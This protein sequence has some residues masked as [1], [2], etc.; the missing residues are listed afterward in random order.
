M[1][2]KITDGKVENLVAQIQ[3]P[4]AGTITEII[5]RPGQRVQQGDPLAIIKN[6]DRMILEALFPSTRLDKVSK[7]VD[8]SFRTGISGKAKLISQLG[9]R[10]ISEES[11]GMERAGFSRFLEFEN[12]N[13]Q[14]AEGT[15]VSIRVL[16]EANQQCLAIPVEAVQEEQ[17]LDLVYVQSGGET[18][19][20]RYPQLG[21]SDGQWIEVLIGVSGRT[22][23]TRGAQM[24]RLSLWVKWKWDMAMPTNWETLCY[25]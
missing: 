6:T 17:G 9:G 18:V 3:A 12:H 10:L 8:A 4:Q 21:I 11:I 2:V 25:V 23:V 5:V 15:A 13:S 22:V 20:K 24:V 16:G 1:G 7:P 14:F 19:E